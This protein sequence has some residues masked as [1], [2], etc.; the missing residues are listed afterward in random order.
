MQEKKPLLKRMLEKLR[1]KPKHDIAPSGKL[2]LPDEKQK[3]L[4]DA[5]IDAAIYENDKEIERLIKAGADI[6]AKDKDGWTVM[7]WAASFGQTKNCMVLM[8][9][10][11]KAGGD[12][13][14]LVAMVDN[15]LWTASMVAGRRGHGR[16]SRMLESIDFFGLIG[17]AFIMPF[18]DCIGI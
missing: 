10:C 17:S 9:E 13:K 8:K 6:T 4:N 7:H 12:I 3:N 11:A 15:D 14:K 1:I 2:G 5:L 18:S 16:T